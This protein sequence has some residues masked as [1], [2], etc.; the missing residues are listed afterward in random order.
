VPATAQA[1]QVRLMFGAVD[2]ACTIWLNGEKLLERPYPYQGD[3]NSW[4][5]PFE[6]DLAGKVALDK[7]NVLVV[8]VE[9]NMGA[10]GIWRP[11][12]LIVSDAAVEAIQNLL[13][14]G[15]FEKSPTPWGQNVQCGKFTFG[16][17]ANVKRSGKASGMLQC[18]ELGAPEVE[19]TMRTRAWGR[20]Y[21][22][23]KADPAKTYRF[24]A[25]IRT[26]E[27]FT[28]TV[29]LW[30]TGTKVGTMEVKGLNTQ[31][32]WR[33]LKIADIHPAGAELGIYL[34]VMDNTGTVWFD[35][36]ELVAVE[37]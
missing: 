19:K 10:G 35:D 15:G 34:N 9:D 12:W 27:D 22:A 37:P 33:E 3:T 5:A 2:E 14:D 29:R 24:R 21:T 20:Y 23:V 17:D 13:P 31:G 32:L 16:L 18:L 4:T 8:R 25:W 1:A 36:V 11:V 30:V 6:V 26:S 28:G 7:P